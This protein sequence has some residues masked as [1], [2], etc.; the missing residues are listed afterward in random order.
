MVGNYKRPLPDLGLLFWRGRRRALI[1]VLPG[2]AG[3]CINRKMVCLAMDPQHNANIPALFRSALGNNYCIWAGEKQEEIMMFAYLASGRALA[4]AIS[5]APWKMDSISHC[6]FRHK[7]INTEREK[8]EGLHTEVAYFRLI[9]IW[10]FLIW[11]Q[12][13]NIPSYWGGLIQ[14]YFLSA[15]QLPV[16]NVWV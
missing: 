12:G 9:F 4:I 3:F 14:A 15:P 11:G 13:I 6:I 10:L 5:E 16:S 7:Y 1:S 2:K 8:L